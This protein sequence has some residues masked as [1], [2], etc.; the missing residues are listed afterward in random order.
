MHDIGL[1]VAL[2][3]ASHDIRQLVFGIGMTPVVVGLVAGVMLAA[4]AT[5]PLETML[6]SV[7]PLDPATLGGAAGVLFITAALACWL[8]ARRATRV[9]PLTA[10]RSE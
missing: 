3:A 5:R 10:L 7:D 8:P 1:R 9:D 2:G 4:L 6:F